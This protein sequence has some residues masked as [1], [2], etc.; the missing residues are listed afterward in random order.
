MIRE[1]MRGSNINSSPRNN[2][3]YYNAAFPT[4]TIIS[5]IKI[6]C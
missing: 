6:I 3:F 4:I 2:Q 1:F 5:V